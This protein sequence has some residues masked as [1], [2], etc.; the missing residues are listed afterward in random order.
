[1]SFAGA[2]NTLIIET[3]RSPRAKTGAPQKRQYINGLQV[4]SGTTNRKA[5]TSD[6]TEQSDAMFRPDA[7][8]RV[9]FR[10]KRNGANLNSAFVA[11]ILAQ[12][13][14]GRAMRNSGLAAA[15][16]QL[17]LPVVPVFDRRL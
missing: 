10:H 9:P 14:P 4:S 3:R 11:Q 2:A 13:M 17:P 1:M 5:A 12:A 8:A 6:G 7:E 15:Y 16:Q